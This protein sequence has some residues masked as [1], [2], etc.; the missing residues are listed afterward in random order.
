MVDSVSNL[1]RALRGSRRLRREV[2]GL[3]AERT[4]QIADA[5]SG[6]DAQ[7]DRR[8]YRRQLREILGYEREA[9]PTLERGALQEA[10]RDPRLPSTQR[11]ML[12]GR[13]ERNTAGY[14]SVA[15]SFNP[16]RYGSVASN[17]YPTL[18]RG[19]DL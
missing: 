14:G 17:L 13:L 19:T 4:Q 15:A 8:L 12:R 16:N 6:T 3:G 10:L 1:Q 11:D 9:A 2:S 18:Y 7:R 5:L